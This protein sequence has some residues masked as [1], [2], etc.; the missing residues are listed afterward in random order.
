MPTA[1]YTIWDKDF[2]ERL[3]HFVAWDNHPVSENI[4]PQVQL[5]VVAEVGSQI[6]TEELVKEPEKFLQM[7]TQYKKVVEKLEKQEII[8]TA[9]FIALRS[10]A[11]MNC[12]DGSTTTGISIFLIFTQSFL[13]LIIVTGK[14]DELMLN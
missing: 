5:C 3:K 8:D 12:V 11:N 9:Q 2:Y 14:K 13:K 6:N 4:I 10:L 1:D 7:A